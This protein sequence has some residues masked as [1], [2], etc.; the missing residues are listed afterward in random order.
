VGGNGQRL[1]NPARYFRLP[2]RPVFPATHTSFLAMFPMKLRISVC[3]IAILVLAVAPSFAQYWSA[4]P[5][6]DPKSANF[7]G[8]SNDEKRVYFLSKQSGVDNIWM[9]PVKGGQP[10]QVTKFTDNGV[11]RAFH[12]LTHPYLIIERP[13]S[14]KGDFHIYK[15]KDDGTGDLQELTKTGAGVWNDLAGMSYNGRYVYYR[16]NQANHE[17]T[18]LWRYDADQYTIEDVFPNDKDYV[19]HAWSRDHGRL[20]VE[21]PNSGELTIIDI[22]S[23]EHTPLLKPDAPFKTSMWDPMNHSLFYIDAAGNLKAT[24]MATGQPSMAAPDKTVSSG[25]ESFEFSTNGSYVIEKNTA[26]WRVFNASSGTSLE[27]PQGAVP[28]T[29]APRET[30]LL[31]T[32]GPKLYLYDI[33]KKSSTELATIE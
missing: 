9:V 11:V 18:D 21:S 14:A 33:S 23:T 24:D 28:L 2:F 15:L 1:L 7:T 32:I 27:L 8:F 4:L 30:Q 5:P 26:G 29:I 13:T 22:V 19:V 16:S 10:T 17:K 25:V 20:L 3:S 12:L 31:Y 6:V